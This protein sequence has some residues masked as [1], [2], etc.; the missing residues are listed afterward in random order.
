MSSILLVDD[1][2]NILMSLEYAFKKQGYDVFI[3]RNG[4]EAID[5]AKLQCPKIVVLDIMMPKLDG[6]ETLKSMKNTLGL[7][8]TKFVFLSAKTKAS[9]IAYGLSIGADKYLSKPFSM[10]QLITEIRSLLT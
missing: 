3:A 10:K 6:Y 7:E 9:D 8:Q 1:E 4:Q 2:P 5:I